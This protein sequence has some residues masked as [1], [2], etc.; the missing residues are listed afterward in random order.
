[1]KG[2][3]VELDDLELKDSIQMRGSW[4]GSLKGDKP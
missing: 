1:M 4:V 2:F 3:Q